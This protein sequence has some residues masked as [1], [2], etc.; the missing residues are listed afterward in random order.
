MS[1]LGCD[2]ESNGL[3]GWEDTLPNTWD[4][5]ITEDND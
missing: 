5:D 3:L 4:D 1:F 2:T